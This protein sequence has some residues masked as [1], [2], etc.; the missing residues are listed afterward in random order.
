MDDTE[1][2]LLKGLVHVIWAD[3]EVNEAERRL[4][5][6]VLAQLGCSPSE[7]QEVAEM[8]TNPPSVDNLKEHVPDYE[9]RQ[10]IM[11]VLLAMA[12]ADG[13]VDMKEL[14]FLNRMAMH[15]EISEGDLEAL[16]KE[17]VAAMEGGPA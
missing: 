4:L 5:G 11:K 13:Q 3:G 8:M 6:G 12:L 10:E 7:I 14:R 9:A 1:R 17:T 15:L 2:A 16:K